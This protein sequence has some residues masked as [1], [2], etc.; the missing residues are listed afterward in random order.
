MYIDLKWIFL[1]GYWL[2]TGSGHSNMILNKGFS[3]FDTLNW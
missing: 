3:M 1:I 2:R